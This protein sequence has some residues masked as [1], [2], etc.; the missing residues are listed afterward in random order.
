MN[1]SQQSPSEDE[2]MM[3]D[4]LHS[5]RRILK[6]DEMETNTMTASAKPDLLVLDSSMRVPTVSASQ[7]DKPSTAKQALSDESLLGPSA[8][9]AM[10]RSLESLNTALEQQAAPRHTLT[11]TTRISN[12]T[13]SSIEDIVR[14]EV[15]EMVRSWLDTNLPSMVENMVRA[16]ITRMTRR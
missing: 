9:A 8:K 11:A 10:D 15:R 4:V 1:N 6:E 7:E 5:I 2:R 13:S 3:A 14:E 16:E 12:G